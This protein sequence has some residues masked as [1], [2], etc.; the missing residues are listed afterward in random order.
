MDVGRRCGYY[1]DDYNAKVLDEN[2]QNGVET[3]P[4]D[5]SDTESVSTE[6][7]RASGASERR[8]KRDAA[9]KFKEKFKG[10]VLDELI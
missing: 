5:R 3:D 4:P 10:W 2:V 9:V 1:V 8:P 7:L 6:E